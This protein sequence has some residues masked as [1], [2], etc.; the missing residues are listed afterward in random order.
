MIAFAT[1]GVHAYGGC[2]K[3]DSSAATKAAA[4]GLLFKKKSSNRAGAGYN[5]WDDF[6]C[7]GINAS[8]LHKVADALVALGL[9]KLGYRYI[10]LDDARSGPARSLAIANW[11]CHCQPAARAA[12]HGTLPPRP[13]VN[14]SQ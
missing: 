12:G 4:T 2:L 11:D 8:N 1:F 6:R 10:S 13:P 3:A 9:D 5:T 7:G 14:K